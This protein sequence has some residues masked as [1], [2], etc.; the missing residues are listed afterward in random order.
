M[1]HMKDH[2]A[3]VSV[4]ASVDDAPHV[5]PPSAVQGAAVAAAAQLF[6]AAGDPERLRLLTLLS[7]GSDERPA[8]A[9]ECTVT[10]LAERTDASMS[11]V[12][13]RLR[14]LRAAG[15]VDSR[16]EGKR[17]FYRVCDAH[18]AELIRAAV[19]HAAEEHMHD[20]DATRD[21]HEHDEHGDHAS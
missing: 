2:A 20:H 21:L 10:D 19:D 5:A 9:A 1:L 3:T 4:V 11:A 16:R 17:V 14:V 6:R 12:S 7:A 18:V 13:Q 8:A 15:L